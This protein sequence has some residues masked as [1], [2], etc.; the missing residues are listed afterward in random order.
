MTTYRA[1]HKTVLAV[2]Q[3]P[4]LN[5]RGFII[6]MAA[7]PCL[8]CHAWVE[9]GRDEAGATNPFDPCWNADGDFGCDDS[10][11]A[12]EEGCGDHARPYDLARLLLHKQTA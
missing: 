4:L 1:K 7:G 2:P 6:S 12:S 3:E 11:E 10:P 8:W 5:A 9:S